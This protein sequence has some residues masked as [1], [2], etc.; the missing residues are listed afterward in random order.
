MGVTKNLIYDC[1]DIMETETI[2]ENDNKREQKS[3]Q[4]DQTT[5]A[6]IENQ[7]SSNS[8]STIVVPVPL[9]E[10]K[11]NRFLYLESVQNHP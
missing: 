10:N 11:V 6:D 4:V 5:N 3:D 9:K 8:N 2:E 7:S 1:F